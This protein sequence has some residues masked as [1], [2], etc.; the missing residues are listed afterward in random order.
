MRGVCIGVGGCACVCWMSNK[1]GK[2][3]FFFTKVSVVGFI[4]ETKVWAN[5]LPVS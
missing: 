4:A 1:V 5:T 3:T 2:L